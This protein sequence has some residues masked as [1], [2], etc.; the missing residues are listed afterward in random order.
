MPKTL[1]GQKKRGEGTAEEEMQKKQKKEEKKKEKKRRT[2]ESA[3]AQ[4]ELAIMHENGEGGPPDL[5]EARRLLD[6]AAD[7]GDA[8]AQ[9]SLACMHEHGEGGPPDRAKAR[10]L[11]RLA[12]DQFVSVA[13]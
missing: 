13:R 8:D 12:A 7:Q 10:R 5:V 1:A 2:P 11:Y 6:L 9:F 4:F 3:E